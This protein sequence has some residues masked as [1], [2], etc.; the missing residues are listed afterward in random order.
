MNI[1][2]W[3]KKLLHVSL[4]NKIIGMVIGLIFITGFFAYLDI[5]LNLQRSMSSELVQRGISVARDVAARSTD[6]LFTSNIYGLDELLKDTMNNNP[7]LKYILVFDKQGQL[8]LS[9]FGRSLPKG[10]RDINIINNSKE[11]YRVAVFSSPDGIIR[12]IAVPAFGG[13][14]G[15]VRIGITEK[16]LREGLEK[17]TKSLLYTTIGVGII[18]ILLA[19]G[20]TKI[21]T[22]PLNQLL[23]ATDEVGKGNLDVRLQWQ[24]YQDEIGQLARAFNQMVEKIYSSQLAIKQYTEELEKKEKI[25]Q[26]LLEKIIA[27][28]EDERKRIAREL[29]DQ[30][31][32]SLASLKFAIGSLLNE[33]SDERHINQLR[34]ILKIADNILED[35]HHLAWELRPSVLDDLGLAEAIKNYV[36]NWKRRFGIEVDLHYDIKNMRLNSHAE[37]AIYRIVQEALT[38]IAKYSQARNVSIVIQIADNNLLIIIEDDGIGFCPEPYL[39]YNTDLPK[40]GLFGMRERVTLLGGEMQIESGEGLGCSLYFKIPLEAVNISD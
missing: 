35:L 25:R 27:A 17:T 11:R 2:S 36:L 20:L 40:L 26:Q 23:L 16:T 24:S 30:T 13:E 15:W 29:H 34:E 4:G 22:K 32:Q 28:Q 8:V 21:L 31:S 7:D 14:A 9:T 12:D 37:S 18:G 19:I 10:L 3:K 5:R 6:L 38:N 39:N 1:N 33:E